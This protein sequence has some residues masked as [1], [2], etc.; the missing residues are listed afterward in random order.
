MEKSQQFIGIIS[1]L[2]SSITQFHVELIFV[3]FSLVS[4]TFHGFAMYQNEI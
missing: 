2:R 3:I 4:Q 1:Q